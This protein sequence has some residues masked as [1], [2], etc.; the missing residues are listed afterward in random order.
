MLIPFLF[1]YYPSPLSGI[2]RIIIEDWSC[3]CL[4]KPWR[5]VDLIHYSGCSLD[6]SEVFIKAKMTSVTHAVKTG[7]GSVLANFREI[8]AMCRP[9]AQEVISKLETVGLN[10]ALLLGGVSE[11]VCE[12]PME[13][14][15]VGLV[16]IGGLNP[17]AAVQE[18]GIDVDFHA[19]STVIDYQKLAPFTELLQG[20]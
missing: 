3:H 18:A 4:V 15:R 2:G 10:A 16:L 17:I 13:L 1:S 20:G 8:P 11:S 5:F 6:P 9:I 19:M 12:T 7:N 14:N